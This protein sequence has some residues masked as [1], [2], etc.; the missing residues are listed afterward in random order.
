MKRKIFL[1]LAL[2]LIGIPVATFAQ[3]PYFAGTVGNNNL[4]GY[5][6]LKL[7]PGI[8]V[9]ETYTTFQYGIGNSFAS[10]MDLYTGPNSAYLGILVRYGMKISPY[11]N[12]GAQATP[13]FNLNNNMRMD[14]T[15]VA[16]Y[17][18]G[19]ITRNKNLIWTAN[20]WWGINRN[21]E[22]TLSQY[23]YLGYNITFKNGTTL[24]PMAGGI[25]S[26]KF[27]Q[28]MDMGIGAYYNVKQWNF[29]LWCNDFFKSH[30]R[31]IVGVDFVMKFSR[32]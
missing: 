12:I 32:K 4:Y 23:I 5:T 25:Y 19:I 2:C 6:S 11:F 13:S 22:Y 21:S 17:M 10:G 28:D 31:I 14:Y 18:D 16:L 30:P 7:R 27:D 24:T 29:Y 1:I 20:T 15:T 8:N 9:Q 26:W 3:I